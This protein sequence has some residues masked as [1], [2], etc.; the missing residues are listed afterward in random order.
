VE[1]QVKESEVRVA[2][3]VKVKPFVAFSLSIAQF[4][5]LREFLNP[6]E[7]KS[8]SRACKEFVLERAHD[9]VKAKAGGS[10]AGAKV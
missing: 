7:N 2:A 10:N 3:P 8:L 4:Q 6:P 9:A 1:V 5:E